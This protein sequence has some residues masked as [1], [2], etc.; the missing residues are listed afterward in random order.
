MPLSVTVRRAWSIRLQLEAPASKDMCYPIYQLG[1][2]AS[3][4]SDAVVG[5]GEAQV[6]VLCE[7]FARLHRVCQD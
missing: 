6:P 7:E 5:D 1:E 4:A 3:D 2:S